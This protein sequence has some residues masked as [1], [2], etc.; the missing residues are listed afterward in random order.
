MFSLYLR[1]VCQLLTGLSIL[2]NF[3]WFMVSFQITQN[4]SLLLSNGNLIGIYSLFYSL[5]AFVIGVVGLV[6]F[7]KN[8]S[9][10]IYLFGNFLIIDNVIA[11]ACRFILIS[12]AS[13]WLEETLCK[14]SFSVAGSVVGSSWLGDIVNGVPNNNPLLA[15]EE[16]CAALI[17]MSSTAIA[18]GVACAS[19]IQ[20]YFVGMVLRYA[21]SIGSLSRGGGNGENE[22][23]TAAIII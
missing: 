19:I 3:M 22:K 20:F 15:A 17:L 16:N 4:G 1:G 5:I 13:Q 7:S 8:H 18:A 2:S 23:T 10:A 12:M 11:A 21:S 6:G 14:P 9:K